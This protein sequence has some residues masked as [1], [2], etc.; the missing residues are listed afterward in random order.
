MSQAAI[1]QNTSVK[2]SPEKQLRSQNPAAQSFEAKTRTEANKGAMIMVEE[3]DFQN[4]IIN[5]FGTADMVLGSG[6]I[7]VNGDSA[8]TGDGHASQSIEGMSNQV[9]AAVSGE[10]CGGVKGDD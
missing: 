2:S 10:D 5:S 7:I 4:T 6:R 8:G 1:R 9:I 3:P